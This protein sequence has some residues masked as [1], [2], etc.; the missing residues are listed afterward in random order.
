ML[1]A[2]SDPFIHL[3]SAFDFLKQEGLDVP[4]VSEPQTFF[5]LIAN[6]FIIIAFVVSFLALVFSV[7]Q[8]ITSTGDKKMVEKAQRNMLWSGLGTIGAFAVYAI[9][10]LIIRLFGINI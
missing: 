7:I 4:G 1:L 5:I 10:D 2:G 6:A 9:K 3:N 8:F